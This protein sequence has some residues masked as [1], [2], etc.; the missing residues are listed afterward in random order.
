MC[1]LDREKDDKS[2]TDFSRAS[3]FGRSKLNLKHRPEYFLISLRSIFLVLL[4][5]WTSATLRTSHHDH[6]KVLS[7]TKNDLTVFRL[8][9]YTAAD[10]QQ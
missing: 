1:V 3:F 2:T 6:V 8:Y 7:K 10:T 4:E 9:G 5:P